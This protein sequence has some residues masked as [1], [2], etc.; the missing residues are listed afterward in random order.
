MAVKPDK[1]SVKQHAA[2]AALLTNVTIQNAAKEAGISE[3]QIHRWLA[4][5]QEFDAAYRR[6]R[7]RATQ[8]AIA[9]LQQVSGHAV[10]ILLSIAADKHMSPS[11]RVAAASKLLDLAL[12]AVEVEELEA[13]LSNLEALTKEKG[14]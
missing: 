12:R 1:L 4:D 13:R 5:D 2:V 14:T 9:R 7:W 10:T 11:S 3:R 8:Q 6:A